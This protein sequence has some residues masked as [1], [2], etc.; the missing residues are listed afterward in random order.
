M[1]KRLFID[2]DGTLAQFHDVDK[3]F[4][5]AMWQQGF[6]INLKPFE[7]MVNGIRS[8]IRANPDIEVFVL[9]AVLDTD[10]PFVVDEKNEWLDTYLPEVPRNHRIFTRAGE[11][12]ADYIGEL[13]KNDYLIDDYNKNLIEFEAAGGQ[14]VK[15][16]NN[17]NHRGQGAYGGESGPLWN[18][19]MISYDSSPSQIASDLR[20][21]VQL[22]L[23]I[24]RTPEGESLSDK[25]TKAN[26][27]KVNNKPPL[28]EKVCFNTNKQ[29]CK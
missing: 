9:S 5:E 14:P 11:N 27:I 24:H 17:V 6:Y 1:K 26:V 29:S 18:G 23:D 25:I 2:I 3:T 16:R 21:I 8:F 12:K 19:R 20:S 4:I 22:G 7:N 13:S 15:F 28:E 10:P